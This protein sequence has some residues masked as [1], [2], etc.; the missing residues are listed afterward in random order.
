MQQRPEFVGDRGLLDLRVRQA[1]AHTIDRASINDGIYDG[2]GAPTE[3]PVAPNIPFAPDVDRLIT[4]YPLDVNRGS[5]LMAEAGY[6]KDGEGYYA[7]ASGNRFHLDFA[8]F[9]SS[10]LA[11]MQQ[12]LSDSWRRAGFDVRTV[13]MASSRF[14]NPETR[15]TLPG[16]AYALFPGERA[17]LT[18]EIG[19]PANRWSGNNRSGWVTP[20]YDRLYEAWDS[21]LDPSER[22]RY[23]AQMMALISQNL[24]GYPLYFLQVVNS[25]VKGLEGPTARN[26]IAG[27]GQS[28]R[29]T[30]SYWNIQDWAFR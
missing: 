4:R 16:L 18:S 24:P 12:I 17:Y 6:T 22:G 1:L 30:T 25:W 27:F 8:V 11:R 2:L 10:E 7:D 19:T 3:T 13:V 23:V 26:D 14:T 21:T 20:E 5:Q 9:E 28:S 29:A 15:Q